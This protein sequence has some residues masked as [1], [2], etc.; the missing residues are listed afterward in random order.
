MDEKKILM[1]QNKQK[2]VLT[3]HVDIQV[4]VMQQEVSQMEDKSTQDLEDWIEEQGIQ[5]R[6]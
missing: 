6:N 5:L 4:D 2:E 1:E 3:P